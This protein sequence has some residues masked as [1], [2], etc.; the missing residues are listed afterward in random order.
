M[1]TLDM[2][3]SPAG[4]PIPPHAAH[5]QFIES[6]DEITEV[7][8][9]KDFTQDQDAHRR[10]FLRD[11]LLFTDGP[12]HLK[13]KMVF[14]RIFSAEAMM[15][16][17][18]RLLDPTIEEVLDEL[19]ARRG[20]DGVT[21]ADFVPL[22]RAMT[23]R[24]SA[25][26]GGLDGIDTPERTEEYRDLLVK[27]HEASTAHWT[28]K[29]KPRLLQEGQEVMRVMV[30]RYMRPSL[31]RRRELVR[32]HRAGKL[33][34]E[35]LPRDALT[36]I[37]LAG[38][39][40]REGDTEYDA[41]VWREVGFF[42][43]AGSG[44]TAQTLPFVPV[45]IHEWTRTHPEDAPKIRDAEFLRKCFGESMRLHQTAPVRFRVATKDLELSTGR[46]VAQ[47]ETV[48]LVAPS[49]N[50]ES[51]IFGADAL[52]FNPCRELPKG[53]QP[54][55]MTFGTGPHMCCGRSLVTGLQNKPGEEGTEGTAVKILKKLY[56]Y[57]MELDPDSP[58]RR[59]TYSYHDHYETV[60]VI[61][62]G[63]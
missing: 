16:Y 7:M 3:L 25:R 34:Q 51:A 9:S 45:H 21:R 36:M 29:D 10:I 56:G 17:E 39:D 38:D 28:A 18:L 57:G 11:T 37:C 41:Y 32:E 35:D 23:Y 31:E 33:A 26:I 62:R 30:D 50:R 44:T 47:G 1:T 12:A 53:V 58:P 5:M 59:N 20:P 13:R 15:Y 40:L 48:A 60:P 4:S 24:I 22:V 63:L 14:A 61:L 54:W 19:R 8:R 2:Q 27:L 43:V 46:R 55:G 52:E 6:F 49:A 42:L